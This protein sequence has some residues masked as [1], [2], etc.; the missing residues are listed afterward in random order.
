MSRS[1]P[2][3]ACCNVLMVSA[4]VLLFLTSCGDPG[5]VS[6]ESSAGTTTVARGADIASLPARGRTRLAAPPS[7][8]V[9]GMIYINTTTN[10]EYIFD[11][12]EW[13]P[14]DSSVEAFY[15]A[16]PITKSTAL[17]QSDVFEDG[18][19][20]ATPSGAHGGPATLPPGH[21]AFDCKVCHKVGGRLVFDKAGPAYA[22]GKPVP[23]F[24]ATAKTCSN[25]AC[26]GVPEGTFSYYF[27]GGDGE[28]EL[29]TVTYGG[30]TSM[31]TPS[32]YSTGGAACTACHGNPPSR[33]SSGANTW[34]S[35]YHGGAGPTSPL[36]QC[37]FCHPDASS[38]GNSIGDTITNPLLHANGSVNVQA[39]FKISCFNCH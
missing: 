19:P 6:Q 21:V 18:D 1:I 4:A 9:F 29:K 23:S 5:K 22:V 31:T 30:T 34:H 33:G 15:S 38:P 12:A 24:D 35:G 14:H 2:N 10:R 8:A 7:K 3:S 16:R 26:H 27:P 13:V 25:I 17:L 20:A 32:W 28:P 11:G 36:N 37:Q 39:V